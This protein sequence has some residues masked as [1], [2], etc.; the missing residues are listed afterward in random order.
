M[1]KIGEK[2]LEKTVDIVLVSLYFNLEFPKYARGKRWKLEDAVAS[3]LDNF[4]YR[5]L[6]QA[7]NYLAKNGF[8]QTFKD[9]LMNP[10]ITES[11]KKKLISAIPFYD[12]KRVWNGKVYLIT[13][14][15]PEKKNNVRNIL[16]SYLKKIGAGMLQQSVWVTPY[17]PTDVLKNFFEE[18]DLNEL[19]IISS[20]GK[21]GTIGNMDLKQLMEKVYNLSLLNERYREY[22]VEVEKNKFTA[23]QCIFNFLSILNDDPQLP[24]ALLPENWVG[25]KA[26]LLFKKLKYSERN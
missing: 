25:T 11:G 17:N 3:D 9:S 13:Y 26:Y 10:E 21:D 12:E 4:D 24:F 22:I 5:S 14:D 8:V 6:K 20:I 23:G 15:L 19:V 1:Q 2:I 16:R 7:F 18:K